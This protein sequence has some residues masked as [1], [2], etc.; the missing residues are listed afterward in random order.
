MKAAR[1]LFF[2]ALAAV[3]TLAFVPNYD[4]LPEAASFSDTLN[5]FAAFVVLYLLH[6]AAYPS[7]HTRRRIALLLL[8]GVFIETVQYFLPARSASAGDVAVDAA[9]LFAA[10]VL[11][12]LLPRLGIRTA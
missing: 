8:Y 10:A 1:L 4:A 7:F 6:A 11:Q 2:S 9:A 3:T 12:N 5:H